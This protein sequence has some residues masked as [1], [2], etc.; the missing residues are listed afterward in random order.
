[1]TMRAA[2]LEHFLMKVR[3]AI[4]ARSVSNMCVGRSTD[5]SRHRCVRKVAAILGSQIHFQSEFLG[6]CYSPSSGALHWNAVLAT[7]GN[8]INLNSN[9]RAEKQALRKLLLSQPVPCSADDLASSTSRGLRLNYSGFDVVV[10]ADGGKSLVRRNLG[11]GISKHSSYSWKVDM[12][13]SPRQTGTITKSGIRQVSILMNFKPTDHHS[14]SN[15]C[16]VLRQTE[17]GIPLDPWGIGFHPK[18]GTNAVPLNGPISQRKVDGVYAVFKRFY[19]STC[20]LQ[21]LFLHEQVCGLVAI[22]QFI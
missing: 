5:G 7:A 2:A 6:L 8:A 16:P 11:I 18:V 15:G 17:T 22:I 14:E 19:Y 3:S 13:S 12:D 21:V 4:D 9:V 1:M 20:Q 10:G